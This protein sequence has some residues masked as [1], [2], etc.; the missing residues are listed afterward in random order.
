MIHK[1]DTSEFDKL[2]EG[3]YNC[4][5]QAQ[6]IQ[7]SYS[8]LTSDTEDQ[9]K[10]LDSFNTKIAQFEEWECEEFNENFNLFE[11]KISDHNLLLS[12]IR[13]SFN[14]WQVIYYVTL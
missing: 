9:L 14:M 10:S 5:D 8:T 11:S 6:A 2:I 12:E 4:K 7:D 3:L 1:I 13:E